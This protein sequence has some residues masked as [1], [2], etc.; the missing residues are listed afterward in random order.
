VGGRSVPAE[1]WCFH[2]GQLANIDDLDS[3]RAGLRCG[4]SPGFTTAACIHPAHVTIISEDTAHRLPSFG[5]AALG[6]MG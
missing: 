1:T 6:R 5:R 4:R 2:T 3:Y